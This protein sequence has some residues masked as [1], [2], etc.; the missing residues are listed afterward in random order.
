IGAAEFDEFFAQKRDGAA[1][2]IAGA[3]KDLG[4]IEKLHWSL[5]IHAR[6][7]ISVSI[8]STSAPRARQRRREVPVRV[9]PSLVW[10]ARDATV[11]TKT[12]EIPRSAS[13]T[14]KNQGRLA[15]TASVMMPLPQKGLPSQ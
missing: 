9:K 11:K 15:M 14:V 5:S 10:I 12:P 4:L 13:D 8:C 3:D 6:R 2:A 1:P 7:V